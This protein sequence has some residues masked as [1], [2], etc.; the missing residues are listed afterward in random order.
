MGR[1]FWAMEMEASTWRGTAAPTVL[2]VPSRWATSI[3]MGGGGGRRVIQ[4]LGA[5]QQDATMVLARGRLVNGCVA[6]DRVELPGKFVRLDLA[7]P[8]ALCSAP[9]ISRREHRDEPISDPHLAPGHS[10][11]RPSARGGSACRGR[12]QSHGDR[13]H[14]C[15]GHSGKSLPRLSVLCHQPRAGHPRLFRGGALHSRTLE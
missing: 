2:L 10:I 3:A 15:V 5:D 9:L 7:V 11:L 13:T 1:C 6:P 14:P 8:A 12:A 4:S